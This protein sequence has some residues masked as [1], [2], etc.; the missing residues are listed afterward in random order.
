M[1]IGLIGT[2]RSI[3]APR[4][5][6]LAHLPAGAQLVAFPSRV[7]VFPATP[8]DR[9]MQVIGHIEA[10]FTAAEAGMDALVIDSFADYGLDALKSALPCP[11]VGAGAAGLAAVSQL[12]GPFGIVTVWPASMNF[13]VDDLLQAH[14]MAGRCLALRNVGEET[15]LAG[16]AGPDGYLDRIA[17]AD[18]GVLARVLREVETAAALGAKAVILGCTCM[19]PIAALVAQQAPLPIISPLA[20]AAIQAAQM[21]ENGAATAL[22]AP[23]LRADLI[24]R[25]VDAIAGEVA[26]DCPV[27]AVEGDWG[28]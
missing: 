21:V 3:G 8:T 11:V 1:K 15:A 27:C 20:M 13:L 16:L 18:Q 5:Q 12:G 19:S 22:N 6:L 10:G 14:G 26:E 24:R 4:A 25:M 17:R 7:G 9:A 28:R 23:P 2:P